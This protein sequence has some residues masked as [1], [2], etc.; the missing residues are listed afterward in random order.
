VCSV[1]TIQDPTTTTSTST[2]TSN[3]TSPPP[4]VLGKTETRG[5]L[6]IT[7]GDAG[8]LALA[9]LALLVVGLGTLTVRR[10]N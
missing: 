8:L 6:A 10:R 7:G 5:V 9:G 1:T 2:P 3:E 4:S